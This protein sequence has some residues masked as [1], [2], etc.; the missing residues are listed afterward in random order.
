MLERIRNLNK[1]APAKH[2]LK[3]PNLFAQTIT[4]GIVQRTL[5]Q[6]ENSS[7]L[8]TLKITVIQTAQCPGLNKQ[9]VALF[10]HQ[11][12]AHC[13]P[14]PQAAY[15]LQ[16]ADAGQSIQTVDAVAIYELW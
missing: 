13:S 7:T 11:R 2:S 3:D 15:P 16:L 5:Q 4:V 14:A 12:T 10:T 1:L 8:H 6:T 9:T